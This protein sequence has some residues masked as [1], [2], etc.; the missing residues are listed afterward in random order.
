MVLTRDEVKVG[1]EIREL[2]T[3]QFEIRRFPFA[4]MITSLVRCSE[5]QSLEAY[6]GLSV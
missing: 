3:R 4:F 5:Y 6:T 1:V 2:Q